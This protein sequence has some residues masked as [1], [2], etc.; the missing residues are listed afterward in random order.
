M[1]THVRNAFVG[2]VLLLSM[3]LYAQTLPPAPATVAEA[4]KSCNDLA[5]G[6][7]KNTVAYW[8]T[9]TPPYATDRT[10]FYKR[11]C[12]WQ[13]DGGPDQA[14]YGLYAVPPSPWHVATAGPVI[15]VPPTTAEQLDKQI[16]QVVELVEELRKRIAALE[17]LPSPVPEIEALKAQIAVIEGRALFTQCQVSVFGVPFKCRLVP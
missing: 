13:A 12:G 2:L 5:Y 6:F 3:P 4:V 16:D 7:Q 11:M 10:Y 15:P 8:E 1:I 14:V 17:G 9:T